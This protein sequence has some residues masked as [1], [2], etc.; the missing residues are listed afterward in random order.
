M[1]NLKIRRIDLH[2]LTASYKNLMSQLRPVN[3]TAKEMRAN[4]LRCDFTSSCP[5]FI[6]V[7]NSKKIMGSITVQLIDRLVC[8]VPYAVIDDLVVAYSFR[9][10]GVG[11]ML[12]RHAISYADQN[13]CS[14]IILNC[15]LNLKNY[16]ESFGF[17]LNGITMRLDL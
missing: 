8:R 14:K 2:D 17:Y 15:D 4:Y 5:T 16:Y 11:K 9:K 6:C 1:D 7:E 13:K 10:K 12:V 3:A